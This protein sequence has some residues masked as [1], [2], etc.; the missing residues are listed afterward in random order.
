LH[1]NIT[2]TPPSLPEDE[3]TPVA[4]ADPGFVGSV[5]LAATSF[6]T[7]SYGWKGSKRIVVELPSADGGENAEK[8]HVMLTCVFIFALYFVF[9][10]LNPTLPMYR[11]NAT[12]VNSK[13][14]KEDDKE[15]K[16]SE[17]VEE[18]NNAEA[19][20]EHGNGTASGE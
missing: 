4:P 7:G 10:V 8:V 20:E 3:S 12:V 1:L 17:V 15:A 9:C 5:A 16:E 2:R 6:S 19:N 11:V 14:A 13:H 18:A